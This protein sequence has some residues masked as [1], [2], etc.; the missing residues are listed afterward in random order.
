VTDPGR[1]RLG[2]IGA[3][4]WAI[5]AHLPALGRRADVEPVIVNRRDPALLEQVREQFGFAEASTDWRDVIAARPD[6]VVVAGPVAL[7]A[8]QVKAALEAGAHVL[9][10]KPFT[11]APADAW[12]L[13][14][15]ARERNRHLM[16]C[17]AWN[18]MGIVE[19]VRRLMEDD[20]GVGHVEHVALEMATVVRDL[21]T[22][23]ATYL[24]ADDYSPPRAETWADPAV[25]GGGYGQGQLT[26]GIGLLFRAVDGLRAT[27]VAA[28]T[29]SA[30][31]APVELHDAIAVRFEGGAIGTIGGASTPPGTFGNVHQLTLRVTGRRG[32]VALDLG[33][34]TVRRSR[35]AGDDTRAE[36]SP[37]DV[38][39]SFDRVID[40]FVDLAAGRTD[41]NRSPGELGA[42]VVEVLDAAYRSAGSGQLE[43]VDRSLGG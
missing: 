2:V 24:G 8:E 43:A 40:R 19:S 7:H 34:E 10:E 12:D 42:R 18:E 31:D 17:Y 5:A 6:I 37:E 28:F 1:L 32:V 36:L 22:R 33:A 16:L 39:W 15:L 26:H 14:R 11:I 29:A 38:R 27:D 23:G 3:G 20:G 13:T 35:G 25:S 41:E 9:C 4:A 21:L 30:D